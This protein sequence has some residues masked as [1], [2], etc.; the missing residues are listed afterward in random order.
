MWRGVCVRA[1]TA[2]ALPFLLSIKKHAGGSGVELQYGDVRRGPA[3]SLVIRV[4]AAAVAVRDTPHK[5]VKASTPQGHEHHRED[6]APRLVVWDEGIRQMGRGEDSR[7]EQGAR[8][9]TCEQC[10]P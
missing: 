10:A 8:H 6:D 4:A 1:G 9:T 2:R 3:R 7:H 5:P